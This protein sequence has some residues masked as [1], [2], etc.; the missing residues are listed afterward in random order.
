MFS[1]RS[2]ALP[3]LPRWD[4]TVLT[5]QVYTLVDQGKY[6]KVPFIIGDQEDEGTLFAL[7][8]YNITTDQEAEDWVMSIF[9]DI[10]PDIW[11]ELATL[12][13]NVAADGS[14][15]E[16]GDLNE[17]YPEYKRIAA[18][19]GDF[20]FQW[21]RRYFLDAATDLNRWSYLSRA[22]YGFPILGTFHANDIIYLWLTGSLTSP[23]LTY[24][25]FFIAFANS[26]NPN[27]GS[28]MLTEW[29]EYS[30]NAQNLVIYEL[31]NDVEDDNY[32]EAQEVYV[33]AHIS[34]L[35]F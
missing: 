35:L 31:Y 19:L 5:D 30:S 4:G 6:S 34:D 33:N 26:L 17:W 18:V 7:C 32:R 2:L 9:E 21:P 25:R 11:D 24:K 10:T 27:T 14:P 22:Q 3:F 28:D 13:P 12:Y 23:G 20:V 1:Y 15:F 29:P 8:T 16:T